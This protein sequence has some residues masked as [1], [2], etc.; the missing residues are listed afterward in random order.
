MWLACQEVDKMDRKL[1]MPT[2]DTQIV[3]QDLD[4]TLV[5]QLVI[6]QVDTAGELSTADLQETVEMFDHFA[7]KLYNVDLNNARAYATVT[8]IQISMVSEQVKE[9][10]KLKK[11]FFFFSSSGE[12]TSSHKR[13]RSNNRQ[14]T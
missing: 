8:S 7:Y 5:Q 12:R 14:R 2:E 10:L 1:I 13:E 11:T 9:T 6:Q 3:L 4:D